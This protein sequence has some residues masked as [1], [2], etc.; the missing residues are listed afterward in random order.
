MKMLSL[1]ATV[2]LFSAGALANKPTVDVKNSQ[3]NWFAKKVVGNDNHKGF[4]PLAN[5]EV[6][7]GPKGEVTGG[8]FVFNMKGFES[9]DLSGNM[10]AKFEGHLKSDDF[11]G[12]EKPGNDKATLKITKVEGT[13]AMGELTIMGTTKPVE[14]VFT[15]DGKTYNG[16]YTLDRTQFGIKYGSNNF[17]K[18]LGDK[19]IDDKVEVDFKI[20]MK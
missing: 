17:F 5:A 7:A 9:T 11:F 10:K 4:I 3:V 15:Q 8:T 19:A 12:V 2:F 1:I 14:L 6:V 13:K 16:K 18:G 20:T